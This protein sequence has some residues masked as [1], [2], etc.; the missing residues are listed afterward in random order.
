[1]ACAPGPVLAL[2]RQWARLTLLYKIRFSLVNMNYRSLLTPYPY[3]TQN[4][5]L[6]SFTPLHIPTA[7]LY[8]NTSFFPNTVDDWNAMLVMSP[9]VAA[10]PTGEVEKA[11]QAFKTSMMEVVV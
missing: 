11:L 3:V 4:M 2:R 9:H 8:Y 6:G 7:P 1:M 5:P 10:A